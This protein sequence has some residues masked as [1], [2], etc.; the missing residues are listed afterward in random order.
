MPLPDC[1]CD[2]WYSC[3]LLIQWAIKRRASAYSILKAN[4]SNWKREESLVGLA[5]KRPQLAL[6]LRTLKFAFF[7][8]MYLCP[9]L[10]GS[11]KN[12]F[13]C[14]TCHGMRAIKSY[15]TAFQFIH[16]RYTETLLWALSYKSNEI[17]LCETFR[18]L[19]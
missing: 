6:H 19:G 17:I 16:F 11:L 14:I 2:Q 7:Q 18:R 12:L 1:L 13:L 10:F 15:L 9:M 4:K 3:L 8:I 5:D